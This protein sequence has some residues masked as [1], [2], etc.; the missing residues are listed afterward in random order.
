MAMASDQSLA[1]K[2]RLLINTFNKKF[3]EFLSPDLKR[4]DRWKVIKCAL[5]DVVFVG[6]K[7]L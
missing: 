6:I 3:R 2:L 7:M 4:F 1:F 5:G